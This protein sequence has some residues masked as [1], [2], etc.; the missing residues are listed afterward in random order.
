MI[1]HILIINSILNLGIKVIFNKELGKD[2]FIDDIINKY[3]AIFI[4]I[5]GNISN[6]LE[7]NGENLKGVIGGNELLE[8]KEHINIKDKTIIIVGGGSVSL[9]VART[10]I[11]KNPKKVIVIY[12]KPEQYMNVNFKE[13]EEAKKEGI[14]FI[15]ETNIIN[16]IGNNAPFYKK[17]YM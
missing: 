9:D 5:G 17:L 3:D 6:K 13:L 1:I 14:K 10:L 16:I 15:F 8:K 2:F 4:G 7:I 12:R 11:K